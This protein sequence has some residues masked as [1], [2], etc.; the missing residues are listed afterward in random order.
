MPF[1]IDDLALTAALPEGLAALGLG[2]EAAFDGSLLAG[3][4]DFGTGAGWGGLGDLLGG[5]GGWL[6][7]N[8]MAGL[9]GLG[10]LN[11]LMN[12]PNTPN[13]GNQSPYA[14]PAPEEP[15]NTHGL[16]TEGLTDQ[17]KAMMGART[18]GSPQQQIT[19]A[20]MQ[21]QT[22]NPMGG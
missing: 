10:A 11:S 9:L 17:Q 8:P 1:V 15:A 18:Q 5:A 4:L 13:Y 22:K 16:A 3:G 7:A 20:L 14:T 2:G 19:Q 12:Q 6:Q 21:Q